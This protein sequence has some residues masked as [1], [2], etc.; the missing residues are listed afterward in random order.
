MIHVIQ[1]HLVKF[2]KEHKNYMKQKNVIGVR[3]VLEILKEM[4]LRNTHSRYFHHLFYLIKFFTFLSVCDHLKDEET[5]ARAYMEF[6][7]TQELRQV[8]NFTEFSHAAEFLANYH[9]KKRQYDQACSYA[10]KCLEFPEVKN[11]AK[12]IL[13]KIT[14]LREGQQ[15]LKD[16]ELSQQQTAPTAQSTI[17]EFD[18]SST[19]TID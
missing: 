1:M 11:A 7:R 12:D 9:V 16:K 13:N 2:M 3:I 15:Q 4:H 8:K 18:S 19:T 14:G 17:H 5:A 10:R 6:I